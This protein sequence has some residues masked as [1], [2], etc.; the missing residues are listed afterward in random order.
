MTSYVAT[1]IN[2]DHRCR[3]C[4][5][6][7][8]DVRI[9]GC[10]CE[11]HARCVPLNLIV[12][13]AGL[14]G[15]EIKPVLPN[16]LLCPSCRASSVFRMYL[17][18]L[19][20]DD[21]DRAV[22]VRKA[23]LR[24]KEEKAVASAGGAS[25]KSAAD[26]SNIETQAETSYLLLSHNQGASGAGASD[27]EFQRTGRWTDDE[28][29]YV[30]F[31]VEAFDNGRITVEHGLKLN[32][33]L[34][35]ILLCKSSRLTKKM[36]NARL[37]VRSYNFASP[38]PRLDV[39]VMSSLEQKFLE[40]IN[41]E[42]SRLE[43]KF[44]NARLWRSHLSNLC[45]QI[46][47]SMLDAN[48]W[49]VSLEDM[50]R[51]AAEAE[52]RLRKARRRRMGLALRTDV[53]NEQEGVFFGGVPVQR[54]SKKHKVE[55][56]SPA[57][58]T[59]GQGGDMSRFR[60]MTES[61]TS[62]AHSVGSSDEEGD[63]AFI[64][65]ILDIGVHQLNSGAAGAS[66]FDYAKILGLDELAIG[67]DMPKLVR[68]NCGPF[69]EEIVHYMERNNL[70]FQ[71]VDVWVPSYR[72]QGD[73]VPAGLRLFHAGYATCH[74]NIDSSLVFQLD[75]YGEYSTRF[76]F[77]TGVG[78]PG[79]VF[80]TG[81]PVW[82]RHLDEADPKFFERA[83]GAKVYGVKTGFG[84]PLTTNIIGLIVVSMYSVN[85]IPENAGIVLKTMADLST[86]SPEPKW[87][88]V[89]EMGD[90]KDVSTSSQ[91]GAALL[92]HPSEREIARSTA[93]P[94]RQPTGLQSIDD[95]EQIIASMLGEYMPA[96]DA[97][98]A[99][100]STYS[101][102]APN[103]LVPHFMS[104]RLLLL[105]SPERRTDMEKDIVEV[106]KKS[107]EGYIADSRRGKRDVAL[108][109]VRDWQFLKSSLE[110]DSRKPAAQPM[111]H[112]HPSRAEA[113][114]RM[115]GNSPYSL[116]NARG[117]SDQPLHDSSESSRNNRIGSGV[118]IVDDSG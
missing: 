55:K 80:A 19:S 104:L 63:A 32:D 45:L 105:R 51:R 83:G 82:E 107:Y 56:C 108:L 98:S 48:D 11:I 92:Q 81:K 49:I 70:P 69:L 41:S 3:L 99:G 10:G 21:L 1:N 91:R 52:E 31:L 68:K 27:H 24:E 102:G 114:V 97:S 60:S 76:S 30:D 110:P 117:T 42:A 33:F 5:H 46:G 50:E 7:G 75:E 94:R 20:S 116:S 2:D 103:S 79:R 115:G 86:L 77:A 12:S 37:S 84:F 47:S 25:T 13:E 29:A 100:E 101:S 62:S 53:R 88:L 54:P 35:D 78:L 95:T 6:T 71:H 34:A 44:N 65:N 73:E 26:I 16:T 22:E 14:R 106:I 61:P 17:F 90:I 59:S 111:E 23:A 87:K 118:N 67:V 93:R 36:K 28:I 4:M 43:L 66:D 15:N 40:S 109:V 85:D 72:K 74:Y 89:V 113:N 39:E 64:S 38:V 96:S 57:M 9:L 8:A 58:V 18:P 112:E